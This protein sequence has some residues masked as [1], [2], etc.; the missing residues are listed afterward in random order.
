M[1]LVYE[2]YGQSNVIEKFCHFAADGLHSS[3]L[4]VRNVTQD[5]YKFMKAE[6]ATDKITDEIGLDFSGK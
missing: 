6:E 3:L 5:Y 2:P 4:R 1:K